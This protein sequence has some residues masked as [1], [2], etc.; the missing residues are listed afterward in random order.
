VALYRAVFPM[1]LTYRAIRSMS[2]EYHRP[3]G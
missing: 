1:T 3:L 2:P